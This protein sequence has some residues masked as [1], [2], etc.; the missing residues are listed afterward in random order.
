[1][2][3]GAEYRH[4][5]FVICKHHPVIHLFVECTP[6]FVSRSVFCSQSRKLPGEAHN[7]SS[8][9]HW[10]VLCISLQ[11]L[12]WCCTLSHGGR[13][14]FIPPGQASS[15]PTSTRTSSSPP[16]SLCQRS[17]LRSHAH[18]THTASLDSSLTPAT[19]GGNR[20]SIFPGLVTP[21]QEEGPEATQAATGRREEK[22]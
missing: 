1:M 6:L 2:I 12:P 15:A 13:C 4:S 9:A 11:A 10:C 5:F 17:T 19:R 21:E 3:C 22:I 7:T 20:K 14:G 18:S 16:S 8:S